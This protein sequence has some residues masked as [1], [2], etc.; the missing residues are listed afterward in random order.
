MSVPWLSCKKKVLWKPPGSI[1]ATERL[2]VFTDSRSQAGKEL[3]HVSRGDL[4]V[5]LMH[6]PV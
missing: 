6:E 1:E 4:G 3:I 5:N 2:L